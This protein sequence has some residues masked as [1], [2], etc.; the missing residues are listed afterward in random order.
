M[1]KYH[2]G[3]LHGALLQAAETILIQEGPDGVT[4][5]AAA[6]SAGVSHAAPTHH[7]GDLSGLLSELA[8]VG[9]RRFADHLSQAKGF[10]STEPRQR[11]IALGKAYVSFAELYPSMFMLMFRSDRL[12]LRRPA[13]QA[14]MT[15]AFAILRGSVTERHANQSDDP[16]ADAF[17]AWSVVHGF[18]FLLLDKR[19]PPDRPPAELLGTVLQRWQLVIPARD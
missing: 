17:A 11:S 4:L 1:T 9:Y 3:A 18:A 15:A 12:D 7:F 10:D 6:R 13:L 16:V 2:H 19:L 5:R 8:A 14:A